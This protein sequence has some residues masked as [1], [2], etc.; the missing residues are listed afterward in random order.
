[1]LKVY[2]AL[3]LSS[4]VVILVSCQPNAGTCTPTD[5]NTYIANNLPLS[6]AISLG[7][8]LYANITSP[9]KD[10]LL[11]IT[12]TESCSGRLANWLL[13]QCGGTFNASS[14]YLLCLQTSNTASVGRYCQYGIPPV[15]NADL[16]IRNV[17]LACVNVISSGL[18]TDGCANELQTF[19]NQLGCCYQ[20]LYNNTFF[21][22]AAAAIG[23]LAQEDVSELQ[24]L[25]T[26]RLWSL[27]SVT[28]PSNCTTES[29]GVPTGTSPNGG[30]VNAF[31]Q[32]TVISLVVIAAAI[33]GYL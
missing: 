14:L 3:V 28:P 20:S 29:F 11:A 12:C 16:Q 4:F 6:C 23:E 17:F 9:G 21:F 19:A 5:V 24:T 25:G 2:A 13:G 32:V 33:I 26:S 1:M 22:K 15:Y 18:C 7:N 30:S 8:A 31:S 27:C 10:G